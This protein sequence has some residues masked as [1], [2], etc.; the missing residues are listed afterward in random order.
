M[1]G[2]EPI[3]DAYPIALFKAYHKKNTKFV[4]KSPNGDYER[5]L[6]KEDR[7]DLLKFEHSARKTRYQKAMIN[8]KLDPRFTKIN[9]VNKGSFIP[10]YPET[11]DKERVVHYICGKSGSG[12][13]YLAKTLALLYKQYGLNTYLITPVPDDAYGAVSVDINDL[14]QIDTE[15]SYELAL[16]KYKEAKLK[17]KMKKKLL[18]NELDIDE[19]V[20]LELAV[21]DMKPVKPKGQKKFKLTET[22][23]QY[24]TMPSLFIYDDTEA[25]SHTEKVRF[26]QDWQL[27]TGRHNDIYMIIINH[28]SSKYSET[29]NVINELNTYTCFNPINYFTKEFLKRYMQMGAREVNKVEEILR[30]SR[31]C[32]IY[33]DCNVILGEHVVYSY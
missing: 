28:Q 32:T 26:L 25:C 2:T 6:S 24:I 4:F 21:E 20:K 10:F 33:K 17:F 1:L 9:A 12:K 29:R 22:Y 3:K 14:V 18:K 30:K 11:K 8:M 27:L 13:S 5:N 31:S 16:K 19:I 15:N 23:K 7:D